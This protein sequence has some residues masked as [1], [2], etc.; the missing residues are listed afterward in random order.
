MNSS[1]EEKKSLPVLVLDSKTKEDDKIVL[2]RVGFEISRERQGYY[3][4]Q[5]EWLKD[6]KAPEKPL[7]PPRN[8][9]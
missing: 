4:N 8:R 1:K 7:K 9:V 3:Y 2:Q 6:D 5:E